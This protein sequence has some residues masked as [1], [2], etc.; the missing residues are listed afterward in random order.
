MVGEQA[1]Q[2]EGDHRVWLLFGGRGRED[3]ELLGQ[4]A[5]SGGVQDAADRLRVD[6]V[7]PG[8]G[9]DGGAVAERLYHLLRLVRVERGGAAELLPEASAAAT[10]SQV[11]SEIM[12]R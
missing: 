1:G 7:L 11:F 3:V 5:G 8:E 2:V 10:P 4:F 6:L 9:L 12:S